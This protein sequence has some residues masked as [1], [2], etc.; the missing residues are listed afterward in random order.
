MAHRSRCWYRGL[1][2]IELKSG[3][4][5]NGHL[6]NCD[7]FMNIM[8][9]EV[10]CTSRVRAAAARECAP[11]PLNSLTTAMGSHCFY[12]VVQDG[13]RFWRIPECYVRGNTIKYLRIPDEVRTPGLARRCGRASRHP[14]RT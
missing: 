1:Q 8:L 6:V 12:S 14:C 4:T 2:L 10:I 11:R 5:Y 13:D 7:N 3:E 9:R